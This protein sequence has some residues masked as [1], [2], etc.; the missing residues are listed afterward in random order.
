MSGSS[1]F[2]LCSI[3]DCVSSLLKT[4]YSAVYGK[5]AGKC[6]S[7]GHRTWQAELLMM[8]LQ[9][10]ILSIFFRK[11]EKYEGECTECECGSAEMFPVIII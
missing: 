5:R 11:T 3:S 6:V 4:L 7:A 8:P 10:M 1:A 9:V 2:A